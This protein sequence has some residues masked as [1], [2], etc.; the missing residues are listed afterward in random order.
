MRIRSAF[1]A[2]DVMSMPFRMLI[3]AVVARGAM[4]CA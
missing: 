1:K 3:I 4:G 2:D